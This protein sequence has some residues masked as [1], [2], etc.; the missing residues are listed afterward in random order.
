MYCD[1]QHTLTQYYHFGKEKDGGRR[2]ATTC[3]TIRCASLSD[4]KCPVRWG[5]QC[6]FQ[7]RNTSA[8]RCRHST[9]GLRST[10]YSY[11]PD[12]PLSHAYT[13][14]HAQI[15]LYCTPHRLNCTKDGCVILCNSTT[16]TQAQCTNAQLLTKTSSSPAAQS[17]CRQ[18]HQPHSCAPQLNSTQLKNHEQH[19]TATETG[20][21]AH[22]RLVGVR[23]R[24]GGC[25]ESSPLQ[26]KLNLTT[27]PPHKS[28]NTTMSKALNMQMPPRHTHG[29]V[30]MCNHQE[31][32]ACMRE[33][34]SYCC[35][36]E[37]QV[38]IHTLNQAHQTKLTNR[39]SCTGCRY[40]LQPRANP[41]T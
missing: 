29:C 23:Q 28:T 4:L 34:N 6:S 15:G 24:S 19:N 36:Q 18:H 1:A 20:R 16:C 25:T 5:C 35:V 14:T 9:Y 21:A 7:E 39:Y 27:I 40:R 11:N 37:A 3:I 30:D 10:K 13:N 38:C 12:L 8:G 2:W 41:V 31:K 26:N 17:R 32:A 33:T 22:K